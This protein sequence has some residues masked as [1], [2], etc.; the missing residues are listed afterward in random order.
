MQ[1][2]NASAPVA[3]VS[4]GGKPRV[5]SGSRMTRLASN[6]GM[7]NDLLA[8]IFDDNRTAP[9]LAAGAGCGRN[10]DARRQPAPIG[11]EF[12]WNQR[13]VR[14]FETNANDL[15]D[16]QRAAAAERDHR[17]ALALAIGGGGGIRRLP[18]SGLG[19]TPENTAHFPPEI[20]S[21]NLKASVETSPGSV[22]TSGLLMPS[23]PKCRGNSCKQPAPNRTLVGNEKLDVILE[24]MRRNTAATE[25]KSPRTRHKENI[26]EQG[27]DWA[28]LGFCILLAFPLSC[29]H[30][31]RDGGRGQVLS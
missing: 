31:W 24:I 3:A 6:A 21:N 20:F 9:H 25:P 1:W 17:I 28:H 10:G 11:L 30:L 26:F 15:A 14:P 5:S 18:W 2:I 27:P 8:A 4:F 23:A 13:L 16:I 29:T 19:W 12:K 7:K 22:T